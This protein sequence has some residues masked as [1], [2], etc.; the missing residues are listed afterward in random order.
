MTIGLA[1]RHTEPALVLD[2]V[3]ELEPSLRR[4]KVEST[5]E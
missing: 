1:V 2:L 3:N 5:G 4:T